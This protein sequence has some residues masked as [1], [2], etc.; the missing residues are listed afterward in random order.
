MQK[1][2]IAHDEPCR[3]FARGDERLCR[4]RAILFAVF[5]RC[6]KLRY[7][8]SRLPA[9]VVVTP[10]AAHERAEFEIERRKIE[11]YRFAEHRREI[12]VYIRFVEHRRRGRFPLHHYRKP[13]V[14]RAV[15]RA[16]R[17]VIRV[18][19]AQYQL[20]ATLFA[21]YGKFAFAASGYRHVAA[22]LAYAISRAQQSVRA[23]DADGAHRAA[24]RRHGAQCVEY[25][26][27]AYRLGRIG[28]FGGRDRVFLGGF[29]A[30]FQLLA[31]F[32]HCRI[33]TPAARRIIFA[34]GYYCGLTE[35]S[36]S[37][38]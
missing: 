38:A 16:Q 29:Q 33:I 24:L 23:V 9:N 17:G 31:F 19:G 11:R 37:L 20:A 34:F 36:V 12:F 26:F 15:A 28:S 13:L 4:E 6:G 25:G 27:T 1:L 35:N 22:L 8:L 32:S 10:L 14:E 18:S 7:Y 3:F 30:E 5:K 2:G 21:R